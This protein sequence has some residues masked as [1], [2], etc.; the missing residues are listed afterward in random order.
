MAEEVNSKTELMSTTVLADGNISEQ[1]E[2]QDSEKSNL[3]NDFAKH[4]EV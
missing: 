1:S 4:I 3:L 2:L